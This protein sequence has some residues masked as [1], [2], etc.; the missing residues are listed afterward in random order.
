MS[1]LPTAWP[2]S[3]SGL[4]RAAHD[5]E[6]RRVEPQGLVDH[7]AGERQTAVAGAAR[8]IGEVRRL[9]LQR[10]PLLEFGC[11][12]QHIRSPEQRAGRGLVPGQDHRRDLIA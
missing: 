11:E 12:R 8:R 7:R 1:F 5:H 9:R 10:H 3:V 6:G 4:Q 2:A